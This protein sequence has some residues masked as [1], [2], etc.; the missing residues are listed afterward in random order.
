VQAGK[1][2][3]AHQKSGVAAPLATAV[4]TQRVA[5][6]SWPFVL[7][8]IELEA[9]ACTGGGDLGKL[10]IRPQAVR[11]TRQMIKLPCSLTMDSTFSGISERRLK[12][13]LFN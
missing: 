2:I 11:H 9:A 5:D 6:R 12:W 13:Y 1:A 7:G 10:R 8:A 3:N 4:Q